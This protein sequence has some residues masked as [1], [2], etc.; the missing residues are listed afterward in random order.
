LNGKVKWFNETKGYGFISGED[1]TDYFVHMNALAPGIRLKENAEV[2]FEAVKTEKGHQ[3][4]NVN[5]V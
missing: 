5:L 4:Q 2:T 1:G 3:A